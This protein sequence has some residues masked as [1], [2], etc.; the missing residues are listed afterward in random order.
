MHWLSSSGFHPFKIKCHP[1]AAKHVTAAHKFKLAMKVNLSCDKHGGLSFLTSWIYKFP[2]CY[3]LVSVVSSHTWAS[4]T[5][6]LRFPCSVGAAQHTHSFRV[7]YTSFT[8][9]L[10]LIKCFQKTQIAP[11]YWKSIAKCQ[12]PEAHCIY[13]TGSKYWNAS[14]ETS[15]CL[16][17]KSMSA[18][19]FSHD[20]RKIL[21]QK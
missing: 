8:I 7:G 14:H 3:F 12:K 11:I 13:V 16:K 19:V 17:N 18:S 10:N 6:I 2:G 21:Q 20:N 15:I 4:F 1:N 5:L 9:E